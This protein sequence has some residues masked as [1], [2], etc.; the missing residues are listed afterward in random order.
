M[1]VQSHPALVALPTTSVLVEVMMLVVPLKLH[2]RARND[3]ALG[4]RDV[5]KVP[6]YPPNILNSDYSSC[7]AKT[8]GNTH[9]G[10]IF[11]H[12]AGVKMH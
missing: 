7:T 2:V 11:H 4:S 10:S 9:N 3:A 5:V 1:F 6:L 8:C 12:L